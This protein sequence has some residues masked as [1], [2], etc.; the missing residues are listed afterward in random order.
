MGCNYGS[1]SLMFSSKLTKSCCTARCVELIMPVSL[2]I[3]L[4]DTLFYDSNDDSH[5]N[6]HKSNENV[7]ICLTPVL[8]CTDIEIVFMHRHFDANVVPNLQPCP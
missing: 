7:E 5:H 4:L 8:L 1:K 2:V 6:L 3:L